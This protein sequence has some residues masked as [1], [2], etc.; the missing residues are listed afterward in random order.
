MTDPQ[1][2]GVI[3][4]V[5][6]LDL[7]AVTSAEGLKGI[8][9]IRD[10]AAVLVRES[11]MGALTSIPMRDVASVIPIVDGPRVNVHTGLLVVPGDA[12]AGPGAEDTVLVVTGGL[13][14]TSPAT[15]VTHRQVIV[16][17]LVLAPDTSKGA[18]AA[19]LTRVT[20]AVEYYRYAEGQRIKTL[21]GQVKISGE[22]LAN[23]GGT[24]DD[25]LVATGQLIVT[26]PPATVGYQKVIVAGQVLAPREGEAVLGPAVTINGIMAWYEGRPRFFV[27]RQRFGRGF[28]ELVDEPMALGLVGGF[29]I[30]PDVPAALLRAKISDIVLVGRITASSDVVPVLQFLTTENYGKIVARED[31]GERR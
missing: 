17:G 27:G 10:V 16:T 15:Q 20:G 8:T 2:A 22:T 21:S 23:P 3:E 30:E 1:P 24:A 9:G 29:E 28:F 6:M 14:L 11:L 4:D 31:A 25:V 7:T 13:I 5:P 19:G 26:S 12:L 18:L